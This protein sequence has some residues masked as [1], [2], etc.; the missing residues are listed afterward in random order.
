MTLRGSWRGYRAGWLLEGWLEWFGS[1]WGGE[2][3]PVVGALGTD[4]DHAA[5]VPAVATRS[6]SAFSLTESSFLQAVKGSDQSP[7]FRLDARDLESDLSGRSLCA[8]QSSL[9]IVAC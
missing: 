4:V 9:A 6:N 3:G 1:V 2:D 5:V 8:R 7:P